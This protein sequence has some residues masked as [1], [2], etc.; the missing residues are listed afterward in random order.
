VTPGKPLG[1]LLLEQGAITAEQLQMAEREHRRTGE[2]LGEIL[3][4]LGFTTEEVVS[5]ALAAQAGVPH[6]DLRKERL[7]RSLKELIPEE[8][9]KSA[10]VV[11][12]RRHGNRLT[13][14]MA[15]YF[16]IRT[17]DQLTQMTGLL[18]DVVAAPESD[19]ETAIERLYTVDGVTEI[20]E[21]DARITEEGELP[22]RAETAPVVQLVD[23]LITQAIRRGATD[24][25]IEPEERII[26]TRFR[27]D[28]I[29]VPGPTLP[30]HMLPALISRIKI[31]AKMNISETRLPQDGRIDFR[32]GRKEVDLRV[33]TFPTLWGESVVLRILDREQLVLGLEHLGFTEEN[34]AEY[35][36]M[37]SRPYGI[38]LVTGPTGSG[39]TTTLY[40][41]LLEINSLD[42]KIITLEDPVEYH[43]PLI[44]QAQ[45]NPK[46][47]LTFA[48]GL[49]AIFRQD[50]DVIL[51]GEI[52]DFET[53]EMA[54]RAALTGH[55]VFSTVHT[56]DAPSTISR[57]IDM[58]VEPYMIVST[59]IAI[60]AQRLVR[61]LC[62]HC[63]R[64]VP[65]STPLRKRLEEQGIPVPEQVFEPVGCDQCNGAGY[66]GRRGVFELLAIDE[67][68]S[69]LVM[70]RASAG[71][72][73]R[74][75]IEHGM[76]TMYHDGLLKLAAGLT[77][78]EEVLRV[79]V[80]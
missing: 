36:E 72:L 49:R 21:A 2:P 61:L 56:N 11:P 57:L 48:R 46:A 8:L 63:K 74:S 79:A 38:I 71:E 47:G 15:D 25:H 12:L 17:I 1:Q 55:L 24:V 66:R 52:R 23:R 32:A 60:L 20:L 75:A 27:Q 73:R 50:P 53:L 51:V 16:D 37:I 18:I 19:I 39:K 13:V 41:T 78:L 34:L 80:D 31:M 68:V 22:G 5:S 30:L 44:Q 26:R 69:E 10:K 9:A 35:R 4:R 58:E 77:T 40:S 14:A 3:V 29:L 42:K 7:D 45:I 70:N 6:V 65:V 28:G 33:S 62:T 64:A 76:R 59:L 54:I 43:F 67:R